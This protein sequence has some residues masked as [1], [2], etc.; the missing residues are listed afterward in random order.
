M[1]AAAIWAAETM[2][3]RESS[4]TTSGTWK[5]MPKPKAN[6]VA[7]ETYSLTMRR[8]CRERVSVRTPLAGLGAP[9]ISCW[10]RTNG[11]HR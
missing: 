6:P 5:P 3:I 9:S 4:T 2:P 1:R 8:P 7:N 11:S 10:E